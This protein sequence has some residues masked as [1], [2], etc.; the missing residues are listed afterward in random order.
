L[1]SYLGRF[2]FGVIFVDDAND[3]SRRV[4]A[5]EDAGTSRGGAERCGAERRSV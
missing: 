3:D 4:R 5:V 2:V 1:A